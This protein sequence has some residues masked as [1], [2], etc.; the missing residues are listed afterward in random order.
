MFSII[1]PT[2]NNIEYLKILITSIKVNSKYNH[3]II[4][5]VNEGTDGTLDYVKKNKI[6]D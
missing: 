4:I 3:E 2:Y 1:V 6:T 5:H